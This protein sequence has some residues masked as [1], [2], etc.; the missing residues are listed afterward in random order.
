ME[1]KTTPEQTASSS[2]GAKVFMPAVTAPP[3]ARS[4]P[5]AWEAV[6]SQ[7]QV[8]RKRPARHS[9][10]LRTK[11]NPSVVTVWLP[12]R[13]SRRASSPPAV[14]VAPL[15]GVDK[16]RQLAQVAQPAQLAVQKKVEEAT[17]TNSEA[18]GT[19]AETN[20]VPV[21]KAKEEGGTPALKPQAEL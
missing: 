12:K 1:K 10:K 6:T 18:Q 15:L 20:R 17:P 9:T 14:S 8:G 3:D 2:Q 7:Q 4:L 21:W 19:R 13:R 5:M 16:R 11:G